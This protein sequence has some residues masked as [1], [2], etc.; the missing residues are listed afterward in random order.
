M[1]KRVGTDKDP[2]VIIREHAFIEACFEGDHKKVKEYLYGGID[3]NCKN[4]HDNTGL[5]EAALNDKLSIC[6]TIINLCKVE[7][8][9]NAVNYN[10]K[11]CL[12]KAAYNNNLEVIKL[13]LV[14]GADPRLIDDSG[15]R[16][17]DLCDDTRCIS[18]IST[19]DPK[20]IL[21]LPF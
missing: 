10:Y 6:K 4:E 20:V 11:T 1:M 18:I 8:D 3:P 9:V 7:L 21:F 13:L 12:H 16:P 2:R 5:M 15:S 19:W 14:S 17:V